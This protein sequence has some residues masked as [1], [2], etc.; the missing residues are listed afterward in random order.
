MRT[1]GVKLTACVIEALNQELEYIASLNEQGRA[2]DKDHGVAGQILCLEQYVV[3][4]RES[5]CNVAN[6]E[7][8]LDQLR[9]CAAIAILAL[10]RYGCPWRDGK[11]IRFGKRTPDEVAGSAHIQREVAVQ[12][13][14]FI[15]DE[16]GIGDFKDGWDEAIRWFM[17]E[18]GRPIG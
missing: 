13:Q 15:A 5:W 18:I 12:Q 17:H 8:A 4:A 16:T 6:E 7:P 1:D 10:E 11:H 2:D 3:R 9:K 14:H